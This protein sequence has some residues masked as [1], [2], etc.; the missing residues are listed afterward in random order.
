MPNKWL[1]AALRSQCDQTGTL[2]IVDEIQ[3][4]FGRTGKIF[5]FQHSSIVP[6]IIVFAKGLGGGLPIGAFVSSKENMQT[7]CENPV[8]GHLTTFGG[9]AVCCAAALA[10]IEIILTENLI[11]GI[12]EREK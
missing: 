2:L 10:T 11:D 12:A 9:N 3:T 6:D 8:L 1:L 4:G 7:L 5:G